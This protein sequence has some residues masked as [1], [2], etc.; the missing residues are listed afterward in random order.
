M[1]NFKNKESFSF[2]NDQVTIQKPFFFWV[3][4]AI[5]LNKNVA[6]LKL[7]SNVFF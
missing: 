1:L 2:V 6:N 3:L 5:A 7:L 4:S